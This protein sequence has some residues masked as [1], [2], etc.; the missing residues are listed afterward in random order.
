[1][2]GTKRGFGRIVSMG[3]GLRRICFPKVELANA[4]KRGTRNL[5]QDIVWP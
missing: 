4:G 2:T 5:S 1:M 3:G